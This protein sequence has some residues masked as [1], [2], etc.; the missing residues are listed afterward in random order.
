MTST[1]TSEPLPYFDDH[2]NL[3]NITAP[4]GSTAFLHCKVNLL[5]DKT[6]SWMKKEM[7]AVRLL[8]FGL[9]TYSGDERLS[10]NFE[11]PNN[12][13]LRI[14]TTSG[15]DQ[16][17]YECQVSSHPP[18]VLQI[19][20]TVIVPQINIVDD[21]DRSITDKFYNAGST[22]ELR[23]IITHLPILYTILW[24][25]GNKTLNHD[26]SRGGI[27]VKTVIQKEKAISVLYIAH[28]KKNDSGPYICS[29]GNLTQNTIYVHVINGEVPAAI[30]HSLANSIQTWFDNQYYYYF[31][32]FLTMV[33]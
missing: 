26:V 32:L 12:W 23:C 2:T 10:I 33:L 14:K 11:Q 30:Q 24:K 21:L 5:K 8:T 1:T 19:S 20:L 9:H 17:D 6:V 22:L 13:K 29:L 28:A 18:I 3:T 7:G 4:L 16:G 27:S 31:L 25:Q 15:Q